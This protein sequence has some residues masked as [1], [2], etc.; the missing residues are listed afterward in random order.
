[1]R[2]FGG[3]A[4]GRD[5]YQRF[6]QA[7]EDEYE[8]VKICGDVSEDEAVIGASR[9]FTRIYK[10]RRIEVQ[11]HCHSSLESVEIGLRHAPRKRPAAM[12]LDTATDHFP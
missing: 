3:E 2:E 8:L 9:F 5:Y 6:G 10:R 12:T 4:F 11:G 1:M 7:I